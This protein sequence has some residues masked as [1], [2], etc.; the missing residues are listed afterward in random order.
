M[1]CR[2]VRITVC[3][4]LAFGLVATTPLWAGSAT[5]SYDNLGQLTQI[6][7]GDGTT[8]TYTYDKNGNRVTR[9][10]TAN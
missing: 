10:V 1:T 6:A 4:T 9:A 8:I 3:L 2:R 7:Y 5:Y